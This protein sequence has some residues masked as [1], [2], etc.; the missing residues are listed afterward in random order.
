MKHIFDVDIAVK[1]GV[2]AA[3]I[4]ENLSYWIKHNEANDTNFYDGTYWTFNSKKALKELFPYI[5]ERQISTAMQKL[6]DDGLVITGNYNKLAY[7]RTLWYALTEKGK[8]I[9]HNGNIQDTKN[10]KSIMQKCKMEDAEMSNGNSEN[11]T[12]I[13]DINANVTSDVNSVNNYRGGKETLQGAKKSATALQSDNAK[14]KKPKNDYSIFTDFAKG[15]KE[16]LQVLIDFDDMRKLM[17]KPMSERAKK[18][19]LSNLEKLS[20]NSEEQVKIVEQ[21]IVHN[22]QSVY[23]LKDGN[24]VKGSATV[25]SKEQ[26]TD[27]VTDWLHQFDL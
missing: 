27:G 21:S 17:K 7:D 19:L 12:P 18:I 9:L 4:L 23:A 3:I 14:K 1:Y 6:I 26:E 24:T 5:S 13:P 15:N 8:S 25:Q 2:N 22:W 16:L 11:V 20:D 10:V